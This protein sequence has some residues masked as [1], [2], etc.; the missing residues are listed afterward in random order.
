MSINNASVFKSQS[1]LLK[2]KLNLLSS[3]VG[4][5]SGPGGQTVRMSQDE[6]GQGWY[7][8]ESLYYGLSGFFSRTVYGPSVDRP[9]I[10]GG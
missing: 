9:A 10:V 2:R 6:F 5:P 8:F 7:I 3:V 1:L 4:G